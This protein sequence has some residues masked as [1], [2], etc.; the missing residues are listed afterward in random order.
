M[1]LRRL[2]LTLLLVQ[3]AL[4]QGGGNASIHGIVVNQF[5]GLP[6][7]AATVELL[8]VQRGRVLALKSQSDTNGEF[9]FPD[10]P[11][12][13]GYQ[14]VVS[15]PRLQPTAYGQRSWNEPWVSLTLE[16]GE[17]LRDLHIAVQPLA[18]IRGKV[19]D[20]QGR[21]IQGARVAALKPVY[22]PARVLQASSATSIT[23]ARGF[24]QFLNIPAGTYYVRVNP[25]N[26]D[27]A[28]EIL[29]ATP[30]QADGSPRAQ[31]FAQK[32]PEGYPLTYF[33][34][35]TDVSGAKAVNLVAGGEVN[36]V[37]I[38]VSRARGGRVKGTVTYDGKPL[39]GGQVFL[40]R[41]GSAAESN[42][43]RMAR[44]S[45]GEFDIRGVLPGFYTLWSRT[46]DASQ[47]LWSRTPVEVRGGETSNVE[48][49][50]AP[51]V[52][53]AGKLTVGSWPFDSPPNLTQYAV[54]LI[55][56]PLI[57]FDSS[58]PRV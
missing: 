23:D 1:I 20:A 48:V 53:I 57:P 52:D 19:V 31:S 22:K 14:I 33:P 40:Q 2:V 3:A 42:W 8:S 12:G 46:D 45:E 38:T 44:I 28:A 4:S 32:E 35:T 55:P 11:A 58:L 10:L 47:K 41:L 5:T 50:P 25:A 27:M 26:G 9:H 54:I 18:V 36:D 39:I 30:S 34:S 24:Y 56:N 13:S 17:N 16:P 49:K 21:G 37:D 15:G 29:F 7:P 43:T 51:A 6:Y